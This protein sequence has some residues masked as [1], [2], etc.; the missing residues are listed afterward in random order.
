[1]LSLR[2]SC[3]LEPKNFLRA[4]LP[5][6]TLAEGLRAPPPPK[7]PR[8]GGGPPPPPPPP[9][10]PAPLILDMLA[11][12]LIMFTPEIISVF[13]LIL[14]PANFSDIYPRYNKTT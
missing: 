6:K 13:R 4:A 5:P 7:T 14:I 8:G 3:S 11:F 12:L 1:M 10:A 2:L 9:D